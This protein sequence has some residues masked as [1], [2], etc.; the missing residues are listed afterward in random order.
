MVKCM[1]KS[2]L[3]WHGVRSA[4]RA[5]NAVTS[6]KRSEPILDAEGR[7]G[8]EGPCCFVDRH[9]GAR[10]VARAAVGQRDERP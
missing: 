1:T 5:A 7:D 2:A 3:N 6:L 10:H 8:G 4:D 9:G